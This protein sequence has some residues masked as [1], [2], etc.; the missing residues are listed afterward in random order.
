MATKKVD[1]AA[2]LEKCESVVKEMGLGVHY[3]QNLD[4]FFKGDLDGKTIYIGIH[5][6]PEEKLFNLLHL[7]GH[8]IQWNIDELLRNLGSEL[9]K[10][11]D[12]E[13]LKKLANL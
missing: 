7:A 6:S 4:P 10:N 11:P 3:T 9:Y 8:S 1:F 13:L 5:L 2:V 12:D